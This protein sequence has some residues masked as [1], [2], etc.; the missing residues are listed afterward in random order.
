V[1]TFFYA[2]YFH[3]MRVK[4]LRDKTSLHVNGVVAVAECGASDDP[5]PDASVSAREVMTES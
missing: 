2:E 3:A 5:A 4:I 1:E